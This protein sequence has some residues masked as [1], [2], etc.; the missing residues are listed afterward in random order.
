MI[1]K[2]EYD[3]EVDAA[4]IRITQDIKEGMA[5]KTVALNEDI[6]L[7]F[8]S[9]DKLIGIEILNASKHLD[10]KTLPQEA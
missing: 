3:K 8:D 4:Y 1:M 6:I 5:K 9:S 7:D 10:K 2:I